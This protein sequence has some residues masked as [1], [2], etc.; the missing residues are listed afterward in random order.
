MVRT[1]RRETRCVVGEAL[2]YLE[3][4]DYNMEAARSMRKADVEWERE[5]VHV[6][7]LIDGDGSSS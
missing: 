5:Q 7:P 6:L 3:S 2:Y 1:F 4:N